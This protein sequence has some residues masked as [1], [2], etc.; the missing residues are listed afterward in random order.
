MSPADNSSNA[1]FGSGELEKLFV[2]GGK[3]G[4]FGNRPDFQ[5]T[6]IEMDLNSRKMFVEY[7]P[8]KNG[9]ITI[10]AFIDHNN[11]DMKLPKIDAIKIGKGLGVEQFIVSKKIFREAKEEGTKL[12]FTAKW[13]RGH[14]KKGDNI[15]W[16]DEQVNVSIKCID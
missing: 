15:P 13:A 12:L 3:D 7:V 2:W 1:P 6:E 5:K 4:K 11:F 16:D 14:Y 9:K 10:A 8:K